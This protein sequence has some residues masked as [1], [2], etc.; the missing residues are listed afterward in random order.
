MNTGDYTRLDETSYCQILTNFV[1]N[2]IVDNCGMICFL[3]I[4]VSPLLLPIAFLIYMLIDL[5]G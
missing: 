3:I 5:Y 2:N 1:K 4:I